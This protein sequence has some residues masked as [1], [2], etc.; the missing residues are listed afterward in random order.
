MARPAS[1]EVSLVSIEDRTS[2]ETRRLS[3]PPGHTDEGEE[4]SLSD[5]W[6]KVS[7]ASIEGQKIENNRRVSC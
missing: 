5:S 2:N 7:A 3:K 6:E 4:D 1:D